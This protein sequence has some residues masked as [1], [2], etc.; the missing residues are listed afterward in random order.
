MVTRRKPDCV[1]DGVRRPG[2][3]TA[4]GRKPPVPDPGRQRGGRHRMGS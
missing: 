4:L 2:R 3:G 1:L